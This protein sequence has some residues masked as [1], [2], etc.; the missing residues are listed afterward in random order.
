VQGDQADAIELGVLDRDHAVG[1]VDVGAGQRGGFPLPHAG[2]GQQSEQRPV[3]D[4]S[5]R[6]L[7]PPGRVQHLA[8]LVGRVDVGRRSSSWDGEQSGRRDLVSRVDGVEVAGEA[9]HRADPEVHGNRLDA[10]RLAGPRDRQ[11]DGD[12]RRVVGLEV[13]NEAWQRLAVPAQPEAQAAAQP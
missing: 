1:E 2:G 4:R 9:T 11:V 10:L 13:G 7:E 8:D 5:Q 3:G 12:R 6:R